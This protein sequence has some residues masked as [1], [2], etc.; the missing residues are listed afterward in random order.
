MKP[1]E[2]I[3]KD[4]GKIPNNK[5][6]LLL[7]KNAFTKRG[8]AGAVWLEKKFKE[9]NWR[10]SW[11]NGVFDY[12]HYHSNTHEVLG[13]FSGKALLQL[14][15]E[16]GEKIEVEAG[17]VL[18][19]PAGVGHKNLGGEDFKVVGAYPNGMDHDMNYGKEEER[20]EVDENIAAVPLPEND[21]LQ[22]KE[23]LP[24]IWK[25]YQL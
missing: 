15:G 14:G 18:V 21:P 7:Y 6:P 19:I 24:G 13:V 2:F 23:G 12:H 1:Q 11:R 5:L 10:N 17:N 20:P 22:G 3:F 9:N 4:D 16:T 25:R 8:D